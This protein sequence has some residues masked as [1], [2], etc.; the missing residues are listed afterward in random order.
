MR[1][2]RSCSAPHWRREASF[3]RSIESMMTMSGVRALILRY[4][5]MPFRISI[6]DM[7]AAKRGNDRTV[8][9]PA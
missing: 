1:F 3:K 8:I 6:V 4:S 5:A 7:R 9:L 2:E